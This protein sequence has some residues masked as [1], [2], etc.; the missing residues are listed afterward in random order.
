MEYDLNKDIF[1]DIDNIDDFINYCINYEEI[2]NY[3]SEEDIFDILDYLRNNY[4]DYVDEE[5]DKLIYPNIINYL[6][7]KIDE[8]K[9]DN[10]II[11]SESEEDEDDY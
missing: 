2:K 4:Y 9:K 7:K 11:N 3:F 5:L 1:G 8:Y 10:N 6:E